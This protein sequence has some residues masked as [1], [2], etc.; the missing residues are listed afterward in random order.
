MNQLP[1]KLTLSYACLRISIN[2]ILNDL[3]KGIFKDIKSNISQKSLL[4]RCIGSNEVTK[5][6]CKYVTGTFLNYSIVPIENLKNSIPAMSGWCLFFATVYLIFLCLEEP[7][8]HQH[9][10][11]THWILHPWNKVKLIEQKFTFAALWPS[12]KDG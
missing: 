10:F 11:H 12:I 4:W 8:Y 7:T 1:K 9:T 5:F 6:Y 2:R 3:S